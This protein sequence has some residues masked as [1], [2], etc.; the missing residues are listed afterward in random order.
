L[1]KRKQELRYEVGFVYTNPSIYCQESG[2]Q[3]P[4]PFAET[5][6]LEEETAADLVNRTDNELWYRG[7]NRPLSVIYQLTPKLNNPKDIR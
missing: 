1:T 4:A 3:R 6:P 7:G 5:V 2:M